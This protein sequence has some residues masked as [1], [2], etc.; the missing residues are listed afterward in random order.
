MRSGGWLFGLAT[1]LAE[2]AALAQASNQHLDVR[3]QA[4][5]ECSG[6]LAFLRQVEGFLGERLDSVGDQPLSIDVHV[7]GDPAHGYAAKLSFAGRQGTTVRELDHPECSKLSEAAALLTALAI[8]PERVNKLRERAAAQPETGGAP[9]TKAPVLAVPEKSTP[10]P[11]LSPPPS[12]PDL[13][14]HD[15]LAGREAKGA[16]DALHF[17]MAL[18]GLAAKGLLPSV[19]PGLGIELASRWR[20]LE[21]GLGGRYWLSRSAAVPGAVGVSI[22]LSVLTASLRLCL[23]PKRGAWSVAGCARGDWGDIAGHG[24]GVDHA[25]ARHAAYAG[26]GGGVSAAYSIGRLSPLAGVEALRLASRP[27]FGV[28][29]DDRP[30]EVFRPQAWQITGF[31]GLAYAL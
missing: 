28:L 9:E 5:P 10:T 8:D 16:E 15:T 18:S 19:G 6:A 27:P 13:P 31:V 29:R 7:L 25:R 12:R 26:L 22:D 24:D 23:A 3:W 21:V 14:T 2:G 4:P 20:W 30:Q 17:T 11:V 1:F